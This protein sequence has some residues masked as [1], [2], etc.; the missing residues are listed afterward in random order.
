VAIFEFQIFGFD[1]FCMSSFWVEDEG[2][3][4]YVFDFKAVCACVASD[5]TS[6]CSWYAC[7]WRK[8]VE[9][10]VF[11]FC[12]YGLEDCSGLC[13][14]SCL[15]YNDVVCCDFDHYSSESFVMK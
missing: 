3:F 10:F 12:Y 9:A 11:C 1:G 2:L 14:E 8:I 7:E 6:E 13:G 5:C 4:E 15:V